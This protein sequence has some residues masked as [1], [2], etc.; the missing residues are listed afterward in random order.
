MAVFPDSPIPSYEQ[1]AT[2]RY[3]TIIS[4]FDDGTEQRRT[5]WTFPKYDVQLNFNALK[6]TDVDTLWNFFKA[7]RGSYEP[8]YYFLGRAEQNQYI[9]SNEYVATADGASTAY[10]LPG[11]NCNSPVVYINSSVLS[12][13]NY[14]ITSTNGANGEDILHFSATPSSGDVITIDF[15][16]YHKVRVRFETDDMSKTLFEKNLYKTGLK[17]K[18]LAPST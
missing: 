16:G 17:L 3:K 18:G 14:S 1:V 7:R 11:C 13:S 2:Q 15:V 10:N 4:Q 9:I 6:S 12:T 8:F 5:K